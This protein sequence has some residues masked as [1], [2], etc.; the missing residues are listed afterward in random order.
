MMIC[1]KTE[2]Q[3]IPAN[4][5]ECALCRPKWGVATCPLP[6]KN[7]GQTIRKP[8]ISKRHPNCPLIEVKDGE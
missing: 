2:M 8:C 3:K 5:N 7:G 4:C 1:Y 6:W